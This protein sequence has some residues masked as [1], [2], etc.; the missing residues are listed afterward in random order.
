MEGIAV[1]SC[2]KIEEELVMNMIN[3]RPTDINNGEYNWDYIVEILM[4]HKILP[5]YFQKYKNIIPTEQKKLLSEVYSEHCNHTKRIVEE[6]I[7][8]SELIIQHNINAVF[9]KGIV[10]SEM[11]YGDIFTRKGYDIDILIAEEHISKMHDL[12]E[13]MGYLHGCGTNDPYSIDGGILRLEKPTLKAYKH[14][15]Y[16]EYFNLFEDGNYISVE[17]QIKV[18]ETITERE[19]MKKFINSTQ[20]IL[21]KGNCIRTLDNEHTLLYLCESVYRDSEWYHRGPKINKFLDVYIFIKNN[22]INLDKLV[23]LS[24]EYKLEDILSYT[25][26]LITQIFEVDTNEKRILGKLWNSTLS[27][28]VINWK[29]NI[30]NRLFVDDS[31][32]IYE[33]ELNL[34]NICYSSANVYWNEPIKIRENSSNEYK[35][36]DFKYNFDNRYTIYQDCDLLIFKFNLDNKIIANQERFE[37][38]IRFISDGFNSK[39]LVYETLRIS[40]KN[41]EI[42]YER[43]QDV[44]GLIV[45]SEN[46][47]L[48]YYPKE[49]LRF[50]ENKIAFIIG[51]EEKMLHH[52][53]YD[54]SPHIYRDKN[55]WFTLPVLQL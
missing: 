37:I 8:I 48:A 55:V 51:L 12:L 1:D 35:L 38:T 17:L 34:Q 54:L 32:R 29:N 53:N 36:I 7:K 39:E 6:V 22:N 40:L 9:I 10:L 31:D 14:H 28:F 25:S 42:T 27:P 15:E 45:L 49:E 44:K 19:L 23:K 3:G 52:L 33:L 5:Y 43:K 21:I 4:K 11:A 20:S 16:F 24:K 46:D 18:H 2:L 50:K 47:F 26:N 13:Q 41:R 30:I